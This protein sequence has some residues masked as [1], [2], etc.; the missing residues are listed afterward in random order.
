MTRLPGADEA[1]VDEGKIRSYLLS[2]SHP[3][4]RHKAAFFSRYGFKAEK[5]E[6]LRSA[7]LL[8]G[9]DNDLTAIEDTPFG[10]K[11]VVDGLLRSPD[12]DDVAVRTVWFVGRGDERPRFVTAHP[13]RRR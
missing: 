4:G 6:E 8:H 12:G 1:L 3:V 11:Y 5:W 2:T 13:V 10:K 7:L 9:K